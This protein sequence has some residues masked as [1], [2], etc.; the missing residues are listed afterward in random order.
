MLYLYLITLVLGLLTFP[1]TSW[2]QDKEPV[3]SQEDEA[4]TEARFNEAAAR[5]KTL[6]SEAK[7]EEAIQA[8][9]DAY[10]IKPEPNIL[11][12]IG[13]IYEKQGNFE[14]ATTFYE[15]FVNEPDIKLAAR[16]DALARLTTLNE[17]LALRNKEKK[18]AEQKPEEPKIVTPTPVEPMPDVRPNHG[19]D[20]LLMSLGAAGLING[21]VFS[22]LTKNA[23]DDLQN[24]NDIENFRTLQSTGRRQAII[25]DS[26][27]ILGSALAISGITM[28]VIK[29]QRYK[30][31]VATVSLAPLLSPTTH[32]LSFTL[33]F[34]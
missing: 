4:S 16:Q 6:Y 34:F 32:G 25:A 8:Y 13:R 3:E 17:V 33:A 19:S 24:T 12:N 23:H 31:N 11:Y 30:K 1:L 14:Q 28:F 20:I 5:A 21:A 22:V 2:A 26:S 18:P 7:F 10:A 15:R 27:I 29:K 9:Q